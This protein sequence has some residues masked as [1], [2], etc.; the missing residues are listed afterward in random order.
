M[1]P[2]LHRVD[3]TFV[4]GKA[5]NENMHLL[6]QRTEEEVDAVLYMALF[7]AQKHD[8]ELHGLMTMGTH[9]HSHGTDRSGERSAF[10]RDFHGYLSRYTKQKLD[11]EGHVYDTR[12]TYDIT[13]LD[14]ES[15]EHQALYLANNPVDAGMVSRFDKYEGACLDWRHWGKTITVKRPPGVLSSVGPDVLT[16][17]VKPP[18]HLQGSPL[19]LRMA[20]KRLAKRARRLQK[21][22]REK[23]RQRRI[24]SGQTHLPLFMGMD[25][26][27]ATSPTF[28]SPNQ[29]KKGR[30]RHVRFMAKNKEVKAWAKAY[31]QTF[32]RK[33]KVAY[34]AM[35]DGDRPVFPVGTVKYRR[36]GFEVE[37]IS[38]ADRFEQLDFALEAA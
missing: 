24:E 17:E 7:F 31:W 20:I 6:V 21:K 35:V 25:A 1:A 11:F 33:Y 23:Q 30:V 10:H 4:S 32:I 36:L 9:V 13:L 18:P 12:G 26:V 15:V 5:C 8:I 16:Y 34:Q 19:K 27:R 37:P 38:E 14:E 2:K 29:L 22:A 3:D 28:K